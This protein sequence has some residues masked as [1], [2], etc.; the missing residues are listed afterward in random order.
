MALVFLL[1]PVFSD[2]RTDLNHREECQAVARSYDNLPLQRAHFLDFDFE[3]TIRF[4]V[5]KTNLP[6]VFKSDYPYL[7]F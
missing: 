4:A 3:F 2:T 1:R 7:L 6:R 5:L